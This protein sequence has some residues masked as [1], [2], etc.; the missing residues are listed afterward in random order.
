MNNADTDDID[1]TSQDEE[2]LPKTIKKRNKVQDN[3]VKIKWCKMNKIKEY[4]D[5]TIQEK[6]NMM[7]SMTNKWDPLEN[8][9]DPKSA[10]FEK[11]LTYK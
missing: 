3:K 6:K 2:K 9:A 5:N 8:I 10:D 4:L 11:L 1:N 7:S